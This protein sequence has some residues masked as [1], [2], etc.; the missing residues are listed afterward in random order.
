MPHARV[1][2]ALSALALAAGCALSLGTR[3]ASAPSDA[4]GAAT[5]AVTIELSNGLLSEARVYLVRSAARRPL[6]IVRAQGTGR[7]TVPARVICGL[8]VRLVVA[9]VD[10]SASYATEEFATWPSESLRFKVVANGAFRLP[11]GK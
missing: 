7:F 6:G 2:L 4:D 1:Q 5:E 9:A 11:D 3:E 10:G 8:D